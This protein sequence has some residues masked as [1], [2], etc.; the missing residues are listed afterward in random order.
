[1]VPPRIR[2]V[3]MFPLLPNG[4]IDRLALQTLASSLTAI[5]EPPVDGYVEPSTDTERAIANLWKE[6]LGVPRVSAADNFFALGGDSIQAMRFTLR[7]ESNRITVTLAQLEDAPS[8]AAL[9]RAIDAQP[10][11]ECMEGAGE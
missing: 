1:M 7:A 6:I 10:A 8:L 4:K 3:E 9:A 5:D 11:S 2:Y